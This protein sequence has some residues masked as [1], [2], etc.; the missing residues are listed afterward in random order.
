MA[1]LEVNVNLQWKLGKTDSVWKFNEW[2]VV[3]TFTATKDGSPKI[4]GG[5]AAINEQG[6]VPA[7]RYV[8]LFRI[9]DGDWYLHSVSIPPSEVAP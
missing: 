8:M 6:D 5:Q 3:P 2:A 9:N 4:S 7:G 1:P